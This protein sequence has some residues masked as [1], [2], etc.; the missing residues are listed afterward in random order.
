MKG[1]TSDNLPLALLEP[2]ANPTPTP[3]RTNRGNTGKS[4]EKEIELTAGAYQ[5]TRT[6]VL[7][8]VDPPVAVI[9]IDDASNPGKKRQRVIFKRNPWLDFAG[10]WSARGGRALLV[11]CKSSSTHR[12]GLREGQLGPDQVEAI[13]AWRMAG[14]VVALLWQF[15]E[16]VSLW[17]PEMI[18]SADA[19]GEKSLVFAD[20]LPVPRGLGNVVWDFLPVLSKSIWPEVENKFAT[21]E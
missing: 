8:K 18:V 21:C 20:G 2:G 19:R 14:G 16:A 15:G 3:A 1:W 9:W 12:L 11:E 4:F 10:V 7:R 13:R 6:A 17:T 5:R